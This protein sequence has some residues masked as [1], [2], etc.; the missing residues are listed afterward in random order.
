M[1]DVH[2]DQNVLYV[3]HHITLLNIIVDLLEKNIS[4]RQ[5]EDAQIFLVATKMTDE[6][7]YRKDIIFMRGL[8]INFE[9][10][11][12]TLNHKKKAT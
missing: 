2:F 1:K 5:S 3:K 4:V 11:D 6:V 7:L 9:E 12:I 8:G 10:T